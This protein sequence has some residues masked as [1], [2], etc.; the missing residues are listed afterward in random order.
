MVGL[1]FGRL[2]VVEKIGFTSKREILFK[3]MCD[4]GNSKN[5]RGYS[6][7]RGNTISC[8]CFNREQTSKALRKGII[9]VYNDL[10]SRYIFTAKRKNI[11]FDITFEKFRYMI[12]QN[13][14]YCGVIP[15]N[16]FN[17][18]WSKTGKLRTNLKKYTE[19]YTKSM[20][21]LYNGIDRID[22]NLG[23]TENNTVTCCKQCNFAKQEFTVQEFKSHV[24]KIYEYFVKG[25]K[26]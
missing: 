5:I 13:C 14:F 22:S 1:R 8:G 6:L 18:Y 17:K 7:R 26:Q 9:I 15:C 16:Y 24:T 4:C 3:C 10:F 21:I 2:T 12:S 20:G 25:S 11:I 23:Y 19:E